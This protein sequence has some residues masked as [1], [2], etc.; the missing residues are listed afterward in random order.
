MHREKGDHHAS[1][2]RK[3]ADKWLKIINRM[4]ET[5]ESYDD[6]RY[7]DALRRN[8]SPLYLRL[9]ETTCG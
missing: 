2:L 3:L 5:G 7:V 4:L 8:S 1:A 6:Q 9:A